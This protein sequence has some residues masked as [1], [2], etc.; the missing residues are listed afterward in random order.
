MAIKIESIVSTADALRQLLRTGNHRDLVRLQGDVRKC[1]YLAERHHQA[2]RHPVRVGD[3][4]DHACRRERWVHGV[5][6]ASV[7]AVELTS[8]EER[9]HASL[10]I[11]VRDPFTATHERAALASVPVEHLR[12]LVGAALHEIGDV[13]RELTEFGLGRQSVH[14][15][16]RLTLA[17]RDLLRRAP[18]LTR[19]PQVFAC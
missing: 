10:T 4:P 19:W 12:I 13:G 6:L 5:H 17:E 16:R 8:G 14:V 11:L 2:L 3:L 15:K 18:T 7:L 9:W 1:S